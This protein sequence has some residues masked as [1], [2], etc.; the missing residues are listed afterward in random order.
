MAPT[1][2]GGAPGLPGGS[3]EK[4]WWALSL[5]TWLEGEGAVSG[6]E[7]GGFRRDQ[8]SIFH[9]TFPVPLITPE[10]TR[11]IPFSSYSFF[12]GPTGVHYMPFR[13]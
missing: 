12:S 2:V 6:G 10:V 8:G 1:R 13:G 5:A 4:S 3:L 11:C 9:D 7:A